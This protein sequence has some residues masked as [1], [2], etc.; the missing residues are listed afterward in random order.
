MTNRRAFIKTA[1]VGL[2]AL[3]GIG[4]LLAACEKDETAT[5]TGGVTGGNCNANGTSIAIAGNHGHTLTVSQADI[6]AAADKTYHIQGTGD[7]DHTVT[8]TAAQFAT[9][10]GNTSVQITSSVTVHTHQVTVS[11]A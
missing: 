7:H 6:T 1:L 8:I 2:F 3:S 10:A 9:L 5:S 4:A 11:C